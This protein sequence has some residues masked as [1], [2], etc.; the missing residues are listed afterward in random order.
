ML[1]KDGKKF[2]RDKPSSSRKLVFTRVEHLK[3]PRPLFR[4]L[5]LCK[6]ETRLEKFERDKV[7]FV[8]N[9]SYAMNEFDKVDS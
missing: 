7:H 8:R 4:L 1:D 5:A 9:V 3:V 6:Y 2:D